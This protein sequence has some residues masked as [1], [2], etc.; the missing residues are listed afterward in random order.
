MKK[1]NSMIFIM[2]IFLFQ[3][4][5]FGAGL[6]EREITDDYWLFANNEMHE[7]SIWHHSENRSGG[8]LI[9]EETVFAIGYND[10]FIIAKS[11]PKNS[12]NQ[13]NKN[14]T[15]FHII[16][17]NKSS[18][19]NHKRLTKDEFKTIGEAIGVP[20]DLGFTIIYKEL[21]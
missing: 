8:E 21:E 9:V 10:N 18:D 20:N 1:T 11:H 17:I 5:L 13:L 19:Y 14:I 7:M 4:C 16:Q 6:V 2:L 15:Q 12:T 3:S